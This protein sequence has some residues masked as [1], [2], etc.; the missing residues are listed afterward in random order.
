[1]WF[2]DPIEQ[3]KDPLSMLDKLSQDLRVLWKSFEFSDVKWSYPAL[4]ER[5]QW[6]MNFYKKQN[7]PSLAKVILSMQQ[8]ISSINSELATIDK[9]KQKDW[10]EIITDLRRGSWENFLT[11]LG[12]AIYNNEVTLN[13]VSA[14]FLN[15]YK[16]LFGNEANSKLK[17]KI[18]DEALRRYKQ[19]SWL[20]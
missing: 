5:L 4:K 6:M 3:P 9:P 10:K 19:S 13:D 17:E 2:N 20:A 12:K 14:V 7:N 11:D 1:M 15:N 8:I 18:Y 16:R